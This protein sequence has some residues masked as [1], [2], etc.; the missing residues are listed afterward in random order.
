MADDV[1]RPAAAPS[2]SPGL[3]AWVQLAP[4]DARRAVGRLAVLRARLGVGREP[5]PQHVHPDRPGRGAAYVY[6]VVATLAPRPVPR[7]VPRPRRDGR[8]V[9]RGGGGHHG[10]GAAG[11]GAGA[12][13]PRARPAQ[14]H[15]GPARAG[16]QD[17]PP[18]SRADGHEE[19]VPLDHVHGGRPAARPARRE[20]AGGRRRASRARS[21]VDESMVT[22]EPIPVEKAP[23]DRGHRRHRQR[24]RRVRD[25]GRAGGAGHAA[26]PD[27]PHGRRGP[28]EPGARSS[29][30]PTRC[31]AYF[32][33]AVVVVGGCSRSSAGRLV[34]PEPRLAYALVNAV[35]VLIIACPCALGLATPMSIMVGTGRGAEA[36]VL[37]KNA[38]ALE[39][40]EQGRHAG[41]GQDGHA[42]RG[43]AAAG[44]G[45][46]RPP[47]Q[48]EA[49]LLRLAAG[50]ERAASTR[51]PRP[52]S[53]GRRSAG[54]TR[55]RRPR[56][57]SRSPGKGVDGRGR[58]PDR[59][60]SA[61]AALLDELGIAASTS[62][63]ARAEALRAEGQTVMLVA[64]D[65]RPA[66]LLGVAD[67]IKALDAGGAPPA[68]TRRGCASS[69]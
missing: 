53:P 40:L 51:W 41:R 64:V 49:E 39:V 42:D 12:A 34:G 45:R 61:T 38:E 6:S 21:A 67:P 23:G 46:G 10:A 59:R 48:D 37:V 9:L 16:A 7:L 55:C 13:G 65:G 52:S 35:A 33:P 17:G 60:R 20:G 36:G 5:Q 47:G 27:R 68:S 18:A 19:D 4:G 11:P 22:G 54:S 8:A 31:P 63:P 30:W 62:W 1:P 29:G 25:A 43:Q 26:G 24:H 44:R 58:G 57:S 56:S 15:P 28:A 14:R 66:G 69:C 3:A 50:L 2:S 32:V